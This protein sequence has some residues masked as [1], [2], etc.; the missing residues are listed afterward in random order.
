MWSSE[1]SPQTDESRRGFGGR[2]ASL[3]GLWPRILV[4]IGGS[5]LVGCAEAG[6]PSVGSEETATARSGSEPPAGA[7]VS[8]PEPATVADFFPQGP[9]RELVLSTCGSCHAVACSAIG[10]RTS[11]RW[12]ALKAD[13]R[14]KVSS[15][16]EQDLDAIFA[17]LKT[18][19]NDAKPE[20]RLPPHF[21]EGGCTPF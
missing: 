14:D 2:E 11:A 3:L 15:T 9:G 13:H 21:L 8:S 6:A 16:S 5:L 18:N 20:P 17:Y 12:D 19:F 10:Q 4:I 7:A 1:A